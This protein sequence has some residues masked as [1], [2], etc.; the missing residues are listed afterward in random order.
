MTLSPNRCS[1]ITDKLPLMAKKRSQRGSENLAARGKLSS[2]ELR[3]ACAQIHLSEAVEKKKAWKCRNG[4]RKK[5]SGCNKRGKKCRDFRLKGKIQ[6]EVREELKPIKG[7][8]SKIFTNLFSIFSPY[9]P[10]FSKLIL[11]DKKSAV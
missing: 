9:Y 5:E 1:A 3:V 8:Y 6:T 7:T 2:K 11:S 10:S 4:L